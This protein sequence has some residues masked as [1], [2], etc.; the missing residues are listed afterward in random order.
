[1]TGWKAG[2]W[3]FYILCG[4]TQNQDT[5]TDLYGCVGQWRSHFQP[6]TPGHK[7]G[8]NTKACGA[9][10]DRLESRSHAANSV[11]ETTFPASFLLNVAQAFKSV[12]ATSPRAGE[13]ENS[14]FSFTENGSEPRA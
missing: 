2:P 1:M 10:N 8:Q 7:S 9:N 3:S 11:I 5:F 13:A 4:T 12:G 6:V 14:Y